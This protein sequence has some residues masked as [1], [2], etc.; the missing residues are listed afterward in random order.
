MLEKDLG[1]ILRYCNTC[2]R[3]QY[4]N[5]RN[6]RTHI[7]IKHEEGNRFLIKCEVCG[8]TFSSLKIRKTHIG[9]KCKVCSY[10]L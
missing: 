8:Y 5:W 4:G 3:K 9:S 6:L 1:K 10:L 7:G 2:E